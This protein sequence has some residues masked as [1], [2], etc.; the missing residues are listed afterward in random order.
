MS[1]HKVFFGASDSCDFESNTW[2][3]A[4]NGDFRVGSGEYAIM[5][6]A[7][8]NK[9]LEIAG[10]NAVQS[11]EIKPSTSKPHFCHKHG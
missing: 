11:P 5:R 8:Y 9:L 4:M 2:T 6:L 7:D 10:E 1:E 3:F